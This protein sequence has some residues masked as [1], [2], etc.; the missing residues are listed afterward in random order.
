MADD[1]VLFGVGEQR[2]A[3]RRGVETQQ[4][5]RGGA[6][7]PGGNVDRESFHDDAALARAEVR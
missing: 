1:D 3:R 6:L 2:E 7:P 5:Q 4:A